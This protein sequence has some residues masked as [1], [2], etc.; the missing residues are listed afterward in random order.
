MK[1]N[2]K[3]TARDLICIHFMSFFLTYIHTHPHLILFLHPSWITKKLKIYCVGEKSLK[4]QHSMK[5]H[6]AYSHYHFECF[7]LL[8]IF[9]TTFCIHMICTVTYIISPLHIA[10]V[11]TDFQAINFMHWFATVKFIRII[12]VCIPTNYVVDYDVEF[13]MKSS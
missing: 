7:T 6:R 12:V 2:K 5:I 3:I 10:Q 4:K 11:V 13:V 9:A 8:K 1:K